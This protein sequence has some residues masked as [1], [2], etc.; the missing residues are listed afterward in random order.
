LKE[1][2]VLKKGPSASSTDPAPKLEESAEP[3]SP[4]E[5]AEAVEMQ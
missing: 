3:S 4:K 2:G 1:F 5:S